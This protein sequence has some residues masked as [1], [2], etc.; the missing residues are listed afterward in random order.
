[1]L[2]PMQLPSFHVIIRLPPSA[3]LND[4]NAIIYAPSMSFHLDRMAVRLGDLENVV[5]FGSLEIDS[6]RGGVVAEHVTADTVS[7]WTGAN[8]V[9]GKWN[10]S[11]AISVN[12]TG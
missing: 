3:Y 8:A 6:G 2:N 10:I 12:S 7:I 4:S 9:R 1:M 11:E 5:R